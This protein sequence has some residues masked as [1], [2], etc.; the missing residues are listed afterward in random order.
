MKQANK[1]SMSTATVFQYAGIF[2]FTIL[3]FMW[4]KYGLYIAGSFL[5]QG[6]ILLIP[7][8]YLRLIK[9]WSVPKTIIIRSLILLPTLIMGG[10]SMSKLHKKGEKYVDQAIQALNMGDIPKAKELLKTSKAISP[11]IHEAAEKIEEIIH[12]PQSKEY[13]QQQLIA[14][15]D[16]Q[17][18]QLINNPNDFYLTFTPY[19][20][21]NQL[22]IENMKLNSEY[23]IRYIQKNRKKLIEAQ[24]SVWDGSHTKLEEYIKSKLQDPDSYK[25][26]KSEWL[27]KGDYIYVRTTFRGRNAFGGIV[28]N[29][30]DA[31]VS[32]NGDLIEV[33][34]LD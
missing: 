23:R 28:T 3:S 8:T 1:K 34:N 19:K 7:K 5:V 17:F 2:T 4:F 24:F 15:S 33:M 16:A 25:H 20:V 18:A 22:I 10:T 29:T 14:L 12:K 30:A 9:D 26:V 11:N 27:D 21:I 13:I 31:K 32:I 6:T